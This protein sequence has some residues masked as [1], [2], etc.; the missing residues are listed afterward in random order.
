MSSGEKPLM[1]K[2]LDERFPLEALTLAGH[3]LR[4][5]LAA[6]ALNEKLRCDL[7]HTFGLDAAAGARLAKLSSLAA[8][9]HD[10][11]KASRSFQETVTLRSKERHP[12]WHEFLSAGVLH[13]DDA[14]R[15][16]LAAH[17]D[18]DDLALVGMMVA[19]HHLRAGRDMTHPR[20]SRDERLLLASSDLC[21]VWEQCARLLGARALPAIENCVLTPDNGSDLVTD[22]ITASKRSD[23]RRDRRSPLL[24]LGKALVIAA[25]IVGSAHTKHT[26]IDVWIDEVLSGGLTEKALN[27]VVA[28]RLDGDKPRDFQVRVAASEDPITV[29]TAGCGNG[30]TIAAYLWARRV[31]VGRRLAFCYPT[32]GTTTA[33]FAD[34]LLAQ[35]DLERLLLHSRACVDVESFGRSPD[36]DDP[37]EFWARD[38]LER[39]SAHVVACTA[40]T[41]LGLMMNWRAAM[42]SLPLW[43]KCCFVFDEVHSYDRALF[44]ALLAFL[45]VVRAP[46]LLM[47]A[48]LSPARRD[49]LSKVLGRPVEAIEGDP[50]IERALRY[51]ISAGEVSDTLRKTIDAVGRN[52]KVLWIVNTVARAQAMYQHLREALE[53]DAVSVYHSRF[54]YRDRVDRQAEVIARFRGRAGF[55]VV[56]TQVCEM[57]L[58][59]SAD[60][61]VTELAPYPSLVQRLGR[62]NRR[63]PIPLNPRPCIWLEPGEVAFELGH[64]LNNNTQPYQQAELDGARS[65]LERLA[66]QPLSQ[67][68]LAEM[69]AGLEEPAYDMRATPF[70]QQT[71]TTLQVPLRESTPSWTVVRRVDL[72][73]KLSTARRD[74]VVRNEISMPP[75]AGGLPDWPRLHGAF[76]VPDTAIV[77]CVKEGASWAR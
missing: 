19:G 51:T 40:D 5:E 66:A 69:L 43:A 55:V 62:L 70:S 71:W 30:K 46:I 77:Y 54:R 22:Y 64:P 32:T 59:L 47:T 33:G 14:L 11:G 37:L 72:P 13:S 21:V 28:S 53:A 73:A 68:D 50:D 48:S 49:A 42:A 26:P 58:D 7:E 9:L 17:M 75:R 18:E 23:H 52:E 57:S 39:W 6:R 60:L 16:W 67:R 31:A 1:A 45:S 35:T 24:P 63:D 10:I 29:V 56:A 27:D 41:V 34:Y 44:G 61:L 25:D 15:P 76:V 36:D 74:D 8:L 3:S 20:V 12:W 65:V 38:V 4:V 2:S